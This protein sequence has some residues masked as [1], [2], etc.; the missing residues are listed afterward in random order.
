MPVK[1]S[2]KASRRGINAVSRSGDVMHNLDRRA[3]RVI[4]AARASVNNVTGAYSRGLI[5]RHTTNR[6]RGSVKVLAT[7]DHSLILERGSG[8]HVIEPKTKQAL[9]W[10]GAAHP[11]ARVNHPGTRALHILRNA[12]KAA[13][14]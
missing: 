4:A 9:H 8:P 5:K 11:V 1:V 7:A 10:A 12:L 2:F 3:D 13:G 6:G 14:R